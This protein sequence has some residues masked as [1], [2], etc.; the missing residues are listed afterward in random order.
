MLSS[1]VRWIIEMVFSLVS[2]KNNKTSSNYPKCSSKATDDA[3]SKERI[4]SHQF[5]NLYTGYQ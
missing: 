4:I 3:E 5:L 2:L 1:P